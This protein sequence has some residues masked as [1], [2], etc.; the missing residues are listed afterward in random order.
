MTSLGWN[1]I[2]TGR[3]KEEEISLK[4]SCF[5]L[6][7]KC[8]QD[9]CI[10]STKFVLQAATT[11]LLHVQ[12]VLLSGGTVLQVKPSVGVPCS[13]HPSL[14]SSTT[15]LGCG[16]ELLA[17]HD[18]ESLCHHHQLSHEAFASPEEMPSPV[19]AL[20]CT[21]HLAQLYDPASQ[22]SLHEDSVRGLVKLSSV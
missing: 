7:L 2:V 22:D 18:P 14:P 8:H 5:L 12:P 11:P 4:V 20:P 3:K 10:Q 16:G 13:L 19:M 21:A 6:P 9:Q 1:K 17:L 15:S